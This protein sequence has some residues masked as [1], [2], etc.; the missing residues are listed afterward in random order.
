M[1][2]TIDRSI[3]VTGDCGTEITNAFDEILK[4]D[5]TPLTEVE[6]RTERGK[7]VVD[8][9]LDEEKAKRK[10]QAAREGRQTTRSRQLEVRYAGEHEPG[11]VIISCNVCRTT[12]RVAARV[13][14]GP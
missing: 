3:K 2:R 9:P 13:A 4:P 11:V 5:G 6:L 12:R 7:P 10:A 8:E 14:R 1:Q